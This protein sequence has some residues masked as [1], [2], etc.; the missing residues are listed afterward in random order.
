MFFESIARSNSIENL[1]PMSQNSNFKYASLVVAA[2]SCPTLKLLDTNIPFLVFSG[3][4]VSPN[5]QSIKFTCPRGPCT[6]HG[7]YWRQR[8]S[9]CECCIADLCEKPSMRSLEICSQWGDYQNL[10]KFL[11]I[12]NR[13][14]NSNPSFTDLQLPPDLWRRLSNLS[15]ALRTHPSCLSLNRSKS[16]SDLSSFPNTMGTSTFWPSFVPI[17]R[18]QRK[19]LSC[20]DLSQI[21]PLHNMH[22]LLHKALNTDGFLYYSKNGFCGGVNQAFWIKLRLGAQTIHR[23]SYS[24]ITDLRSCYFTCLEY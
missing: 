11:V 17:L 19:C 16:L 10:N 7:S 9:D 14:L 21:Q 20:P 15:S 1:K 13:S 8:I 5:M 24:P 23:D 3:T 18:M 22:P 12:L 2:L 4:A 6:R